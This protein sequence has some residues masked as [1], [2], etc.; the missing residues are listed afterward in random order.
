MGGHNIPTKDVLR[1]YKR[2]FSNFWND[3]RML[4]DN[5]IIFDN[6][7]STPKLVLS[8]A[9]FKLLNETQATSFAKKFLRG[10]I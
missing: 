7:E 3:Y 4:A 10:K 8:N 2:S 1:R 6:S 5:W 9:E